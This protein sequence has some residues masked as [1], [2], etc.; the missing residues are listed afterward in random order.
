ML[1]K[2]KDKGLWVL[3]FFNIY[4]FSNNLIIINGWY[5]VIIRNVY[6]FYRLFT[7]LGYTFIALFFFKNIISRLIKKAIVITYII[8][9]AYAI[10]DFLTSPKESFD[11]IPSSI[12]AILIIIFSIF[13]LFEQIKNPKVLFIYTLDKFWIVA[14]FLLYYTGTFFLFIY[15]E[16]YFVD[17]SFNENYYFINNVF[18]LLK[19]IVFSVGLLVKN[20]SDDYSADNYPDFDSLLEKRF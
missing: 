8:L 3:F 19:N 11:S 20:K 1:K 18:L 12:E 14:S 17:P 6:I 9:F 16:A 2:H 15:A 5:S 10:Y 7:I 13:Y 4:S